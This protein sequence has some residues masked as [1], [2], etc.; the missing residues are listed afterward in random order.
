MSSIRLLDLGGYDVP[1]GVLHNLFGEATIGAAADYRFVQ[2]VN[3]TAGSLAT[4]RAYLSWVDPGGVTVSLAVADGGVARAG[5]Y[6]YGSPSVP[7]SFS[8]PTTYAAGV[9]LPS[10]TA[11]QKCLICIKRDP[12]TGAA[13][14]PETN[15]LTVSTA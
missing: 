5:S 10:L 15:W 11:G 3:D 13:A 12:S 8:T 7:G 14:W 6:N 1:S 9:A 4:L 2:V